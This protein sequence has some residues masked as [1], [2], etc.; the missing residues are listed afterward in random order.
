MSSA[1]NWTLDAERL[2]EA[3]ERWRSLRPD[4]ASV[5]RVNNFLMDLVIDP[6]ECGEEDGD[7]GNFTGLAGSLTRQIIIVYVP[8]RASRRV[9]VADINFA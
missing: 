4:A 5:D 9:F 7:T 2:A 1:S 6:F 3:L 8:D